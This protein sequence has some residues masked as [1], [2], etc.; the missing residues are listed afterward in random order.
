[1]SRTGI[2]NIINFIRA[3]EPR[4]EVDLVAPVV[5]QIRLVNEHDLPATWLL[6]YDALID[7]RFVPLLRESL[8]DRHEIGVWFEVVQPQAEKAGIK[9][10]GRYPWDWHSHV[11]FSIGYTP[12]EREKLADVLMEDFR[13]VFG[14][15]PRSMGSWLFDAHLLGYL[16]DRYGLVAACNCKDQWGTDGYN[17]WG[18][19]Y[20]Q[21]Y[22][23]SR[24]NVL[25]PA[26]TAERQIPVPVFRMLGSDPIYQYDSLR[27]DDPMTCLQDVIS[28]EPVY[29]GGGGNPEWVRWFFDVNFN[30]PCLA[31][32]YTQVGQENPFGWPAMADGLTDQI[33]LLARKAAAGEL[34]VETLEASGRWFRQKWPLTP[35]AA[36]TAL[37]DWKNEGRRSVWYNSRFYRTNL[38][39]EGDDFRIRDMHLFDENYHER[40]LTDVC[41]TP[42]SLYDTLPVVDGHHWSYGSQRAGVR[43][44]RIGPED[45]ATPVSAGSPQVTEHG[46]ALKLA[47][48]T[49]AGA[50][51]LVCQPD[52]IALDL[53]DGCGLELTWAP[54]ATLPIVGVEPQALHYRHCGH[55]Y[56]LTLQGGRFN[57]AVNNQTSITAA[58]EGRRVVLA[59]R[60]GA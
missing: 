4:E 12:A 57:R 39:W 7:D 34:R 8:D 60:P 54:Q 45:K 44:V 50:T 19:Y 18:G 41:T 33:G 43:I 48:D 1:M 13:A 20:N 30:A 56:R 47:F 10:R 21:A 16:S 27:G 29:K 53:P 35:A 28:L 25:M 52:A 46:E 5:N 51:T 40:Y 22:Y 23:P 32:G 31:F 6:Q 58:A 38:Y 15:Y 11:G 2:A 49:D 17:V 9:W 42:S 59:A 24:A 37:S 3:V 14:R 55:P 36:I 26:Q